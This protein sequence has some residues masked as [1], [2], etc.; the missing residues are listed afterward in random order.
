MILEVTLAL[1]TLCYPGEWKKRRVEG[2]VGNHYEY[3]YDDKSSDG[4]YRDGIHSDPNSIDDRYSTLQSYTYT[5]PYAH[6]GGAAS[7]L[8]VS[9]NGRRD[10][11]IMRKAVD[12]VR[13]QYTG[14]KY[15]V[16]RHNCHDFR[17]AADNEYLRLG[18]E[19]KP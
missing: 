14:D 9:D 18:G 8:R 19:I 6:G 1:I 7:T 16:C 5:E 17:R 12:N 3:V 10:D 2:R 15:S 4:Y 11:D 13:D